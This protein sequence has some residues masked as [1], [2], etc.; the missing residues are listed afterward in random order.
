MIDGRLS[1]EEIAQ[2]ISSLDIL[3]CAYRDGTQSGV[4]SAAYALGVPVIVS[5]SGGLPEQAG[6]GE[7]AYVVK[8]GD[9]KRLVEGLSLLLNNREM[10]AILANR[11]KQYA[12]THLAWNA[13]ATN[14]LRFLHEGKCA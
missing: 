8:A 6:Y 12:D 9:P 3:V 5:D 4:V 10:R 13:L 7:Y 11:A 2:C 1:D 14:L